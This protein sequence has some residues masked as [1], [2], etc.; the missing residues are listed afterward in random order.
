MISK[1]MEV[2]SVIQDIDKKTLRSEMDMAAL[3]PTDANLRKLAEN[4]MRFVRPSHP[5]AILSKLSLGKEWVGEN[6]Y[7]TNPSIV[8]LPQGYLVNYRLVNYR[9][10]RASYYQLASDGI[11]RSRNVLQAWNLAGH[12]VG[13]YPLEL[14]SFSSDVG[15]YQGLEDIRLIVDNGTVCFSASY[16]QIR[17]VPVPR[18]VFGVTDLK[19]DALPPTGTPVRVVNLT[20]LIATPM[21]ICEKNWMPVQWSGA[22]HWIYSFEPFRL[23]KWTGNHIELVRDQKN[24]QVI[25]LESIRGSVGPV[26]LP[27]GTW[28]S[29]GHF[30]STG[31]G[32]WYHHRWVKHDPNTLIPTS[33]S[34]AFCFNAS[35]DDAEV[36]FAA[37]LAVGH[38]GMVWVTYGKDD[39]EAWMAKIYPNDLNLI[40]YSCQ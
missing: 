15:P 22:L 12:I 21:H 23:L 16:A 19:V 1:K 9:N 10:R 30:Y 40:W 32:R 8:L 11:I 14:G 13:E 24:A 38:D 29:L 26:H 39:C 36:E 31:D 25:T 28:L 3:N 35:A 34:S 20:E 2:G 4:V 17:P 33:I 27:D 18:V 7:P 6:W 5:G 37:G